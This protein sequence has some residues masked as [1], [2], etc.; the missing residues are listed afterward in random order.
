MVMTQFS[1]NTQADYSAH[2]NGAT[3]SHAPSASEWPRRN[4]L[5]AIWNRRWIAV[6][7]MLLVVVAAIVHVSRA[8]PVFEARAR[9][10]VER[11]GPRV[12]ANDPSDVAGQTQNYPR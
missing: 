12:V 9:L 7:T 1:R 11:T 4:P 6:I 8:K 10:T 5:L 3:E 2:A